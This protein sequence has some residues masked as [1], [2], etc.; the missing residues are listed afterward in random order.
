MIA[1]RVFL[2][3]VLTGMI[4]A[5][6]GAQSGGSYSSQQANEVKK[7]VAVKPS[8]EAEA[9]IIEVNCGASE[10]ILKALQKAEPGDTIRVAGTCNERVVITTD[11]LTLDGQG[12]AILNGGGGAPTQ[13][14]GVV[15]ID[16]AK[17]VT[18]QGL[19]IQNGPGEG[20]LGI[21][22]AAFAVRNTTAQNNASTGIAVG[23]SSSAE[24]TECAMRRNGSGLDV[25]TG[26]TA[27]LK[28]AITIT[29][30]MTDGVD[31]NGQSTLEIRGARVV[32]N[33]N[34]GIGMAAGSGQV[35]IFGSTEA[36]GSSITAHNNG[37]GGIFLG[38]S[39]LTVFTDSTITVANNPTGIQLGASLI[40]S[41]F[42]G[43]RRATFVIE[44]ND[45]GL[46]FLFGSG[47]VLFGGLTVRNNHTTGVLADG[48]GA[49]TLGSTPSN[50]SAITNNGTDLDLSFGTRL[51][52]SGVTVGTI[53]CD[54]TVLSRGTTVCP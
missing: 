26:S 46:R 19:T 13:L 22:G 29:D 38:G 25:Y 14:D 5:I 47:A 30:N 21:R 37:V 40:A 49:L 12:R 50:P 43:F 9:K 34:G 2:A 42:G 17:G 3:F 33:N 23:G 8:E 36:Q 15:T 10:T 51:T 7:P 31:V 24:L 4:A 11:R 39:L 52:I 6:S 53:K 27:I 18:L 16:G 32:V 41:P 35:A 1:K 20:I 45:V 48:A 44:N 54:G 28:G